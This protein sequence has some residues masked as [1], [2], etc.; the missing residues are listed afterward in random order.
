MRMTY[1]RSKD[2]IPSVSD[3]SDMFKYYD[4]QYRK[5]LKIKDETL[6]KKRFIQGYNMDFKK[7]GIRKCKYGCW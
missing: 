3:T 4:E 5:N 2:P 1:G 6:S 7:G